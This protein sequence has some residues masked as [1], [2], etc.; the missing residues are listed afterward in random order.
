MTGDA[1]AVSSGRAAPWARSAERSPPAASRRRSA[2]RGADFGQRAV[3]GGRWCRSALFAGIWEAA[4]GH[5]AGRSQAAAAAARLPRQHRRAG[6]VLQHGDALA[7]RRRTRLRPEPR[8]W[9]CMI[10]IA[11]TAVRVLVGLVIAVGAVDLAR[12]ADPLF[13]AGRD[14]SRCRPSRCSRRYRRSPGCR[15]RSSCSASATRR[16]SSWWWSRCS[17]T[18]CSSTISQIDGVN[19]N[20]INVARTMGATKWQIYSRVIIPAIL[21]GLLVVLRLNLFGPGWWCW[22]RNRPASAT[23]SVR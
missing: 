17:S 23:G 9:R 7:D 22:W 19:R 1:R 2:V 15:W 20:L 11:A 6:Q 16:R 3:C 5:S 18:W 12:R 10:T 4:A 21:P 13:P 8:R 14:G